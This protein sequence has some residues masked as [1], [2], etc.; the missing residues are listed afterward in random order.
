M[1]I[2]GLW[3]WLIGSWDW[4]WQVITPSIFNGINVIVNADI[5]PILDII[6][7]II[8]SIILIVVWI[9]LLIIFGIIWIVLS[10]VTTIIW[11]LAFLVDLIFGF[12]WTQTNL[13][14]LNYQELISIR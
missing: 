5:P 2:N 12:G 14:F 4:F 1:R 9:I 11:L 13:I 8:I 10:L 7:I 6:I 3:S